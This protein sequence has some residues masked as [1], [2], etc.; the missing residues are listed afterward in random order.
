M[1]PLLVMVWEPTFTTSFKSKLPDASAILA[2]LVM[3][4]TLLPVYPVNE[5]K[6]SPV[7]PFMVMAFPKLMAPAITPLL[8]NVLMEPVDLRA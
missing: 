2:L 7:P 3:V 4:P 6:T 1:A 8:V 5:P